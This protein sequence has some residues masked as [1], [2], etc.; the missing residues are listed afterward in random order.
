M[1]RL[2]VI[3]AV[4]LIGPVP[5][6]ADE[7]DDYV[8]GEMQRQKVPGLTLAVVRKG[9][10]LKA[11]GYG[12][13][14]VEHQVPAR[15]ETVYQSGSLGKQFTAT[16]VMLLVEDGRLKLD[17]PLSKYLPGTP[18]SWKDVTVRHLLSHTGGIRDYSSAVNMRL[19]Y[20]EDEL[21][22]KAF[23]FTPAFAPGEKWQYSNTG[24]VVLGILISK[25][26]GKF[27]GDVLKERVFNRLGMKTAQ[28]INE[29]DI[30]PNRAAGYRLVHGELKNQEWVSPTFNSTAD[31]SLYLT[32][33]DLIQWD[34]AL[35]TEAVLPKASLNQMWTSARTNDGKPTH[36]GFGWGVEEVNGHRR[37]HHGGAWQGFSS[38]IDRYVD[39]KL[40]VILLMNL[41]PPAGDP[42][43]ISKGV[44]ALYE[45]ALAPK[46]SALDHK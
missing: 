8:R 19:D 18:Q 45:P 39:D 11:R 40:T 32:V 16:A 42:A 23:R 13:A 15:R 17:D 34:A 3:F 33:D 43:R 26:A 14:N 35:Y 30:I 21:L 29:V 46:K 24:Y 36:Y 2:L 9:D 20:T 44:A 38:Y 27:Y 22:K 12:L 10:L 5:A 41:A 37:I 7:I 6:R 1:H 25:V 4:L 28:I 31:G